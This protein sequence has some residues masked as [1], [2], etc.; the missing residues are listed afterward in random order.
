M[1]K[2]SLLILFFTLL[3]EIAS[4]HS[5]PEAGP[6]KNILHFLFSS[7]HFLAG[8]FA[9]AVIALTIKYAISENH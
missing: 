8:I 7:H 1:K 4:A 6:T 2:I 9:V 5:I 3:P